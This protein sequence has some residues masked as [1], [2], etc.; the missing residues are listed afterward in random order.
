MSA[1]Y[2]MY[3]PITGKQLEALRVIANEEHGGRAQDLDQIISRLSYKTTKQNFQFVVRSLIKREL[4]EKL[5]CKTARGKK[6]RFLKITPLGLNRLENEPKRADGIPDPKT[7]SVGERERTDR[8][9]Q[10]IEA[11]FEELL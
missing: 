3:F 2:G 7:S 11:Q 9:I 1:T 4:I 8:L 10:D 6:R 5:E